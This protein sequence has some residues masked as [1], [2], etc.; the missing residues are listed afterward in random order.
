MDNNYIELYLHPKQ[1]DF[2]LLL[3]TGSIRYDDFAYV[4]DIAAEDDEDDENAD[5]KRPNRSQ[6]YTC[7]IILHIT[8]RRAMSTGKN[9]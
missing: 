7:T 4:A 8:H 1:N 2:Y 5:V 3:C 9:L 6:V